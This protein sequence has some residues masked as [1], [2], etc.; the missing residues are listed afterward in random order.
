MEQEKELK[1]VQEQNRQLIQKWQGSAVRVWN[2]TATLSR[3]TLQLTDG[4]ENKLY[5]VCGR[6]RHFCGA[7]YWNNCQF[8]L[9]ESD[10]EEDEVQILRDIQAGF[11]LHCG[12]IIIVENEEPKFLNE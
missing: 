3:L 5:I 11:E 9:I 2:Y 8:E 4:K 6:C 1:L 7:I 12:F 10:V